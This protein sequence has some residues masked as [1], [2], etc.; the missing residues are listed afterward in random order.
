MP[1]VCY[2]KKSKAFRFHLK[3]FDFFL[4]AHDENQTLVKLQHIQAAS[5]AK[6]TPP[7]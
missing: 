4:S 5:C 2:Y 6:V 3:A 7:R 1:V